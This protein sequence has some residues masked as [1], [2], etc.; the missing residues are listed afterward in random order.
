MAETRIDDCTCGRRGVV[1][2]R[3]DGQK[4]VENVFAGG[5]A[6]LGAFG[7]PIGIPIGAF[8]GKKTAELLDQFL[9]DD[10]IAFK[11]QCPNC[12]RTWEKKF[13]RC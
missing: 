2:Y 3:S 1:G 9:G 12:G 8:V 10:K 11:F 13:S 4:Q 6:V 7:G 5:G